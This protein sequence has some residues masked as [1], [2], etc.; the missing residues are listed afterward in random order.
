MEKRILLVLLAA[1]TA[2]GCGAALAQST[3]VVPPPEAG[4]RGSGAIP[5]FDK[6]IGAFDVNVW[7][8]GGALYGG[9]RYSEADAAGRRT[10]FIT[11]R[12]VTEMTITGNFAVVRAVGTWNGMPADLMIE[13]LDDTPSGDWLHIVAKPQGPLTVILER[14]GGVVKGDLVV[15]S[16]PP[17]PDLHARGAG[18]I[19]VGRSLGR[20]KFAADRIGDV[21]EGSIAY[22]E[23]EPVSTTIRPRVQISVARIDTFE[24]KDNTAFMA[25]R[26]TLNGRPALV[27]MQV[28]DNARPD[29]ASLLPDHFRIAAQT[30]TNATEMPTFFYEAGGPLRSGDVAVWATAPR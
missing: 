23:C 13:A 20:F 12:L 8:A 18:T 25:G 22:A 17:P 27:K 3:D 9:F 7:R 1:L 21:P 10:S 2:L 14:A 6:G 26:G 4:V 29:S 24:V 30:L 15:F 16:A 11:T 5:V 28:V 19:A